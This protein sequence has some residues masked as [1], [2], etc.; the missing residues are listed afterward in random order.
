MKYSAHK[1]I[2]INDALKMV[3]LVGRSYFKGIGHYII[4]RVMLTA[5]NE[6]WVESQYSSFHRLSEID[7]VEAEV[8]E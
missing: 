2:C 8:T 5:S 4:K 7:L 1:S 6:I 3:D